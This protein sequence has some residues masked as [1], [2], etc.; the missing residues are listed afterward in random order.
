MNSVYD[1]FADN[2]IQV[3]IAFAAVNEDSL[4][5]IPDYMEKAER[6]EELL[7]ENAHAVVLGGITDAFYPGSVFYNSDW[8]LSEEADI[9]N[10]TRITTDLM[11]FLVKVSTE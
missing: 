6:F 2:G 10:T 7:K 5:E 1:S 9:E 4:S 3:V 8:H 11:Q